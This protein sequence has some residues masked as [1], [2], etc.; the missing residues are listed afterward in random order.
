[1]EKKCNSA[2]N[3]RFLKLLNDSNVL[4]Y[5]NKSL[6]Q[7]HT[8]FVQQI[9]PSH[10]ISYFRPSITVYFLCTK[11]IIFEDTFYILNNHFSV[12]TIIGF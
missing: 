2:K 3:N 9:L 4:Y 11:K 5:I 8:E 6:P 10:F 1:M 7:H 12:K